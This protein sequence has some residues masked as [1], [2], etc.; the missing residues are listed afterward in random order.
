LGTPPRQDYLR[1][2][3][4]VDEESLVAELHRLGVRHLARL[5]PGAAREA[6]SPQALLAGL[7][8]SPA[9]RLRSS[10]IL[11]FLRRPD[12][13]RALPGT[14]EQ[15]DPAAANILRLYYQAAV[16]LQDELQAKLRACLPAWQPLPDL[17]SAELGLAQPKVDEVDRALRSL[18]DL[19]ARLTDHKANW[20]GSYR[21]HISLFLRQL[22]QD[23]GEL[24]HR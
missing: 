9:A 5:A 1:L 20:A 10:L 21:Q 3:T 24:H 7:A 19:H 14:L 22:K 16:Y 18:G 13:S 17:L 15:L 4:S 2:E 12:Y 23:S 8:S 6:I 11:L